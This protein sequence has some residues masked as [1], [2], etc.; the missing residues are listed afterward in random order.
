MVIMIIICW[1]TTFSIFLAREIYFV[2]KKGKFVFSEIPSYSATLIIIK[3]F[4]LLVPL[5]I[6]FKHNDFCSWKKAS[7]TSTMF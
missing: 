2:A 1:Y 6:A 7:L 5:N 4:F 3:M